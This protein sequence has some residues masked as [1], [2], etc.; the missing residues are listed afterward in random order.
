M[1]MPLFQ[2]RDALPSERDAIRALTFAA[3][4]QYA[5]A[6]PAGAWEPLRQAL[7]AALDAGGPAER[8]VAEQDG[9]LLGSV[10][11]FPPAGDTADRSGGRMRWPELRLLAVAPSARGRGIGGALVDACLLRAQQS[12]AAAL[13]LYTSDSMRVAM[14]LYEQKGFRRAPEYDFQP[15]GAELVKAYYRPYA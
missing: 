13:G 2:V 9:E 8:I 6:M 4:G 12:G 5:T 15:S 11:L 7:A 1:A 10:L 14:R 3:Y